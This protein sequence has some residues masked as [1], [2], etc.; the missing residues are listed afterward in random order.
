MIAVYRR[1]VGSY[2]K[3][4][5]GYLLGAFL[6]V[7][8]GIYTM[9]YNLS[10]YYSNFEYVL[11]A[12]G[13]IYLIAVPV[14][15]M[16]SVAEEKKQKTDQLLYSLPISL[17]SVV[18]GKYLAMLTVLALPT[19]IMALYPLILSQFGTIS[20]GTAYGA[21]L[22]FF[23][24]GGCLLSIGLFISSITDSQVAAA[25]ITLL[26]MMLLYFMSSLAS[27][28]STEAGASLNALMLLALI[29]AV[30][31]YIMSK[32]AIVSALVGALLIGGL[33]VW[34]H[35]DSSVFSGLFASM[36]SGISVFDRFDT[37]VNGVFDVTAI[38]YYLS[39][40]GVMLF[41][42]VQV[43]EKRRWSE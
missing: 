1:E 8:A 7:F 22:A 4:V 18:V 42:T 32:N 15:S 21:L 25:V 38:V 28:V 24:M 31:F 10:G 30:I 19:C 13:F 20:Y 17:T 36:M 41:L 12:I 27:Y 39:I 26:A 14:I 23:L 6:L 29:V 5:L 43:M 9:A 3:G 11:S 40:I 33:Q 37:F 35:I 16:R 34:Y 2:F